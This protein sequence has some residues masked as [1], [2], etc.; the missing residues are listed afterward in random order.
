MC[1][2]EEVVRIHACGELC[3]EGSRS[4]ARL[5]SCS[6]NYHICRNTDLFIIDKVA[7]VNEK[8]AVDV[9]DLT[10]HTLDIMYSVFF[11]SSALEFVKALTGSTN[12]YVEYV[13][14]CIGI[15]FSCKHCVLC[16]VHTAYLRT[17]RL[18]A[19]GGVSRAYAL[20]EYYSMRMGVIRG[21]EKLSACRTCRICYSFEFKAGD[22]VGA[23]RVSILV[24]V[25]KRYRLEAC[26]HDDSAVLSCLYAVLL[27]KVYSLYSA[28][29]FAKSAFARL[30]LYT[31][32]LIDNGNLRNSLSKG[33]IY[34]ASLLESHIELV[35]ALSRGAF[36]GTE[37]A[38]GTEVLSDV[39]CLSADIDRKVTYEALYVLYLAV[40][41]NIYLLVLSRIDHLR[42]ED[43][44]RAVE[45]REG[46]IYLSHTAADG[47]SFFNDIYLVSGIR[48]IESG[49]YTCDTAAYN[50][51]ALYYRAFSGIERSV[52]IYLSYCGTSEDDS[53]ESCVAHVLMYPGALLS[54]ICD[55]YHVRVNSRNGCRLSERRLVHTGRT[56]TYDYSVELMFLYRI[57][58]K[59]LSA[60]RA[61]I[62]I[63]VGAYYTRL[64]A[65]RLRYL[66]N[67]YSTCYVRSAPADENTYSLHSFSPYLL[68]FLIADMSACPGISS[69]SFDGISSC[70]I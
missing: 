61:H 43:T 9:M 21:A 27:R 35:R 37:S 29:L 7:R 59:L 36:F 17:V 20:N 19:A 51:R 47:G 14:V 11:N 46:L 25:F 60:F 63:V 4:V 30:E 8:L 57:D 62:L 3:S 31:L 44:R 18:S 12:V 1:F 28:D 65:E 2:R 26:S 53:L 32:C 48:Y 39:S 50:E 67:V 38:S 56:G 40:G 5:N 6:E 24:K 64:V 13:N 52:E 54:Y 70:F 68:Y 22:N 55:L 49:L 15:F 69:S 66:F 34:R 41:H 16:R 10:Y 58:Y 45:G 33:D 42:C 23:A